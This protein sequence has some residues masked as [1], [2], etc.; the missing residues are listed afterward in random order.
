MLG[1]DFDEMRTTVRTTESFLP[2]GRLHSARGTLSARVPVSLHEICHLRTPG[3]A[4]L[5]A[6]VIGF[7]D[8]LARLLPY[9]SGVRLTNKSKVRPLGRTAVIPC[10]SQL[11]G[12]VIDGLGNPIDG[13]GEIVNCRR[14]SVLELKV[15]PP[16]LRPRIEEV[17]P[18]QQRAIDGFLTI[19]LGQRIGLFA[20]SGVGKSTLLGE[21]AKSAEVDCNVIVLVGERGR[22]V[23]PFID[24]CLGPEGLKRSIVVVAT[25]DATP[26]MRVRS[27]QSAVTIADS[28][29]GEGKQVLMLIDSLTRLAMA[30]RE[31]GLALGEPP[32]SRGYTPSVFQL[33]ASTLEQLGN[34]QSGGITAI[35]TVLVDGDDM[36][37]PIA[38]CVRS[39][40]DGHIVLSRKIAERGHF[41]AIDVSASISRTFHDLASPHQVEAATRL[42]AL[43]ATYNENV[44]FIR[45]GAYVPG[46]SAELDDAIRLM[47]RLNRLLQ[48]PINQPESWDS[49]IEA[50]TQL[51]YEWTH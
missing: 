47:P 5:Y 19:G 12:R 29:R 49:T 24:D 34:C 17:L 1:V 37:D 26:L 13:L 23:K 33:L 42:R 9:H 11:L 41:P 45:T 40:V 10:G 43:M 50:M 27:V 30:Q 38:D 6:E 39:I 36:E 25:S 2:T 7:E 21:I 4:D 16:L 22:E 28:L 14:R 8:G 51:A 31:I 46:A 15:P 3:E 48:Q 44:D 32:T 20:G 18:T 35:A